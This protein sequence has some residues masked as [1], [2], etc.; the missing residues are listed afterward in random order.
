MK[1][2]IAI[3]GGGLFGVTI[4]FFLKKKG[5]NCTLFE[6]NKNLLLGASTKNL[7]RIHFGYHYPRDNLTAKQSLSGYQSFK[8]FYKKSI[9][10]KFRNFYLIANKS[11]VSFAKYI[12]FCKNNSLK[13]KINTKRNFNINTN[14]IEGG[15]QVNEPIYDWNIIKKE[16]NSKLKK[17]KNNQIKKNEAVKK[18][19]KSKGYK[20]ITNK[21]NYN[22]DIVID[23]SY[24]YSNSLIE[25][26]SKVKLNKYQIVVVFEFYSKRFEKTGLA[27]MDGNFFSFLPKGKH[28]NNLFYHVKHSILKEK[29]D[30][31]F[32]NKF[33]K[34][35]QINKLINKK[36]EMIKKD[37]KKYIPDEKIY[38]TKKYYINPRMI[39]ANIEKTDRRISKINVISK[40]YYQIYS[41]KVDHCVDIAEKLAKILYKK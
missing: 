37:F 33:F 22:F 9:I 29:N 34:I 41:A 7:N 15:I 19:F 1:K 6:K 14:N 8:K 2:K 28:R 25:N 12:K 4:Y 35:N 11:K 17:I 23:S 40:N 26:F 31:R 21:N 39:P 36:K 5:F 24:E 13:Y 18:I 20:L 27:V 16:V 3:I 32:P 38:F 30:Y 10:S